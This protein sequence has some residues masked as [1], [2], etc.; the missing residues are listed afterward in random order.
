[1][2]SSGNHGSLL[3]I[4]IVVLESHIIDPVLQW[5]NR[6]GSGGLLTGSGSPGSAFGN[7]LRVFLHYGPWET[8]SII[9]SYWING[10]ALIAY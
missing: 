8:L 6:D 1:M 7:L 2:A 5:T 9:A 4:A 10:R 3:V